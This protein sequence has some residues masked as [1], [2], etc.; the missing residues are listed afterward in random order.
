MGNS[1]RKVLVETGI[2]DETNVEI[3]S[4]LNEGELVILSRNSRQYRS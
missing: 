2:T 1:I 3:K 4:G